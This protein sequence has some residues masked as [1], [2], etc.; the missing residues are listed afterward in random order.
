M[1]QTQ[2]I[3]RLVF[4]LI[5]ASLV[6][7]MEWG[8]GSHSFILMAEFDFFRKLIS[9]PTSVLH[10]LTMLPLAGQIVLIYTLFQKKPN[11]WLIYLSILAI[12]LL[13]VMILLSG[14]LGIRFRVVISTIP[15]IILSIVIVFDLKSIK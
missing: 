14:I 3:K 12:G 2:K 4:G 10:P 5:L 15:F 13:Y 8:Q 6:G 9:D 1:S 11:K 7:Y